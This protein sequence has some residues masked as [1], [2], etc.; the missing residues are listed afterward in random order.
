MEKS[1]SAEL[2]PQPALKCF[3]TNN[4]NSF[5]NDQTFLNKKILREIREYSEVVKN[6]YDDIVSNKRVL[7]ILMSVSCGNNGL[8]RPQFV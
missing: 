2:S 3:R 6:M 7:S 1:T 5:E 4:E 8:S